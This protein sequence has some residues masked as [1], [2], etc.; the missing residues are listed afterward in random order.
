MTMPDH[1]LRSLKRDALDEIRLEEDERHAAFLKQFPT[2]VD[3]LI[4][5][6]EVDQRIHDAREELEANQYQI[7][8]HRAKLEKHRR[9]N[10]A[11][12][13]ELDDLHNRRR[14]LERTQ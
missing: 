7:E 6:A 5:L 8:K 12:R 11:I 2:P 3:Q 1:V 4:D 14:G 13:T 10:A 9:A